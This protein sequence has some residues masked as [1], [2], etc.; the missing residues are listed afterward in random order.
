MSRTKR[1]TAFTASY[2][3]AAVIFP[4]ILVAPAYFAD[5]IQLGGL[6]QTASA[7]GS[8]QKALSFFVT[9]YRTLA[10]WRAVVARLDGFETSIASAATLAAGADSIGVVSPTAARRSTCAG[11]WSACPTARRWSRPTASAFAAASARCSPARPA[12]ASRRCSAPSPASGRSAR[13]RSRFRRT[14]R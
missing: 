13:A 9:V 2:S 8:V 12:P 6:M 14:R 10:E 7:F 5:K 3:Q 4:Y 11:S 1:L